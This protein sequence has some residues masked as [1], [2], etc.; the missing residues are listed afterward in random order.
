MRLL[1]CFGCVYL[2]AKQLFIKREI[3]ASRQL[4]PRS[5]SVFFE[6]PAWENSELLALAEI[7][8]LLACAQIS[9]KHRKKRHKTTIKLV[10]WGYPGCV[11]S[12]KTIRV[13]YPCHEMPSMT[14]PTPKYADKLRK[15]NFI[16]S[17]FHPKFW[18]EKK[19]SRN[20]MQSYKLAMCGI[21]HWTFFV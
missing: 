10:P 11:K 13:W 17:H 14:R 3:P 2:G 18:H 19:T 9:R 6:V 4:A 12:E 21:A 1:F 7:N 5:P 8:S 15:E 20:E 16:R